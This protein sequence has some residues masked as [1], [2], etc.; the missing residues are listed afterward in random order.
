MVAD[1]SSRGSRRRTALTTLLLRKPSQSARVLS[2]R[3]GHPERAAAAD[4][5]AEPI[6]RTQRVPLRHE[7]RL[8]EHWGAVR[9]RYNLVIEHKH[10]HAE[11][12]ARPGEHKALLRSSRRPS[13]ERPEAVA[14]VPEPGPCV[15][16]ALRCC[17]VPGRSVRKPVPCVRAVV[18][19]IREPLPRVRKLGRR[20][21]KPGRCVRE[22]AGGV[23]P[24]LPSVH[25]AARGVRKAAPGGSEVDRCA[26]FTR[27]RDG[28]GFARAGTHR[29]R[30]KRRCKDSSPPVLA[31]RPSARPGLGRSSE[32]AAQAASRRGP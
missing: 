18:R 29:L 6:P 7:A 13:R 22:V 25:G 20:C 10:L 11:R 32:R 23:R 14:D 19:G 31:R 30:G 9:R 28:A 5:L 4:E 21:R 3:F 26:R 2:G 17:R 27:P 16:G 1:R 24:P 15:R 8:R 12:L